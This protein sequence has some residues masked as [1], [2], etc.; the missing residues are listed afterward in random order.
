[1]TTG[2]KVLQ[3]QMR[4][5]IKGTSLIIL[6]KSKD[7]MQYLDTSWVKYPRS[8]KP[9]FVA[10]YKQYLFCKG[11]DYGEADPHEEKNKKVDV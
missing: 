1:M 6:Q 7:L 4:E 8:E 2:R 5:G 3:K 11:T 9:S 10:D